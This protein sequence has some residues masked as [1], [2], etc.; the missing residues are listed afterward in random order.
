MGYRP[1]SPASWDDGEQT[2]VSGRLSRYFRTRLMEEAMGL[3]SGIRE[4]R[5][6]SPLLEE[7]EQLA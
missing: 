1:R 4:S 5:R 2:E 6:G 7:R 3:V